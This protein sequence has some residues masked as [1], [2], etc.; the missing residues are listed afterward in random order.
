M[1]IASILMAMVLQS[2]VPDWQPVTQWTTKLGTY[3]VTY[4]ARSIQKSGQTASIW[5]RTTIPLVGHPDDFYYSQ[6]EV[7]CQSRQIRLVAEVDD[8][9]NPD[10]SDT[11]SVSDQPFAPIPPESIEA[12]ISRAA[13]A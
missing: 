11:S 2:P 1:V 3:V 5:I 4:D 10:E 12:I 7:R 13:C 6:L 9:S 8:F